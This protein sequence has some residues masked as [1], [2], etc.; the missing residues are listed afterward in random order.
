[1]AKE[2]TN[3]V[4]IFLEFSV[5]KSLAKEI[6]NIVKIFLEFIKDGI[7]DGIRRSPIL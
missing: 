4:K 5:S 7:K 6:T 1:M 2:I 3:I